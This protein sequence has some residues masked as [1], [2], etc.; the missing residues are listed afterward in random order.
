MDS[1]KLAAVRNNAEWCDLVCRSHGVPAGFGETVWWA[2]RRT[3]PLYPDAVTLRPDAVPA[4]FL[5]RIDLASPGCSVKDSFGVL[6][7][8]SDGFGELFTAEWIRLPA[9]SAAPREPVLTAEPVRTAGQLRGW[10]LAW[11]GGDGPSDVFRP[12]LLGEPSV[13]LVAVRD[14]ERLAGGFVLNRGAGVVG[15][16]NVFTVDGGTAG[17]VWSSAVTAAA[18]YFPGLPVVGHE[19]GDDLAV[20]LASGFTPVGALRVWQRQFR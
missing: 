15:L 6:D 10:H 8:T 12:A 17:D 11:Q 14:G 13:L 1:V 7:L 5:P 2:S 18:T 20:A 9:G 3:P 19:R 4:D 16:S